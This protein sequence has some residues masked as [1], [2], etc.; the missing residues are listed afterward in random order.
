MRT[1]DI[2]GDKSLSY[3]PIHEDNPFLGWRGI[4]V[5]LMHDKDPPPWD[6]YD[7]RSECIESNH[8]CPLT[9]NQP[10]EQNHRPDKPNDVM[11]MGDPKIIRSTLELA[12]RK[13]GLEQVIDGR[14]Q[15]DP[16]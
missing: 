4:R 16:D 13:Q 12:L 6:C 1:L 5:T 8:Y 3:F 2:G 10:D 14:G 7:R 11:M 15:N 9:G